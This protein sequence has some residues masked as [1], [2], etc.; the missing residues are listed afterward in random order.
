MCFHCA[1]IFLN[2][3]DILKLTGG[4][5]AM[6]L[7]IPIIRDVLRSGS[8]GQS[9]AT[10]G[11]W[12][13]LD[14][15]LTVTLWLQHGNYFLSLGYAV[16]GVALTL[17]L[18]KC[19]GFVWGK[20]ETIITLLVLVCLAIWKFSGPRNASIAITAAV[21][22]A[23]APGFVEMWRD[24]QPSARKIW[25]GFTV[26]STLSFFGATTMTVEESLTPAAF[27]ILSFVMFIATCQS[28]RRKIL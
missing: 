17:V 6:L 18:L 22:I 4:L 9:F 2:L 3:H 7:Y 24:P 15:M 20:F 23:V 26:A 28:P 12:A 11:L 5:L 21:C 14:S 13:A 10:W 1:G 8:A 16:G 27:S 19:G 25:A